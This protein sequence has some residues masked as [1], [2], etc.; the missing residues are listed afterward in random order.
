MPDSQRPGPDEARTTLNRTGQLPRETAEPASRPVW[1]DGLFTLIIGAG[2]GIATSDQP[3]LRLAGLVVVAVGCVMMGVASRHLGGRHGRV[4]DQRS[5]GSG[6]LRFIPMWA[7]VF[8]L[9]IVRPDADWQPWYAIG[10]GLVVA[11]VGFGYLRW[12]ERY[13]MRRLAADDYDRNDVV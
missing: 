3:G 2:V 4:L 6:F 10:T 7:V 1:V 8:G 12:D 9:V 13:Q 11:V 5:I